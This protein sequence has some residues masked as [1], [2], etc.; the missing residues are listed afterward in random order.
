MSSYP[1]CRA[2]LD[3]ASVTRAAMV[4]ATELSAW[5]KRVVDTVHV[6]ASLSLYL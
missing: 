4:M 3:T 5:Q 2:T 6:T 1:N